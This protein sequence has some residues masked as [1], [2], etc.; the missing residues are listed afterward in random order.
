MKK[1]KSF[2]PPPKKSIN[3]SLSF[4]IAFHSIIFKEDL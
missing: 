4:S 1:S 2:T 3:F